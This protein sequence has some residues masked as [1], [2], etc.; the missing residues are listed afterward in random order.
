[1]IIAGS[2]AK[3]RIEEMRSLEPASA[4]QAAA[5]T[6]QLRAGASVPRQR[7]SSSDRGRLRLILGAVDH[8]DRDVSECW[9]ERV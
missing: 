6:D 1:V 5:A 7:A 9:S 2:S 3:T 8:D 4:S